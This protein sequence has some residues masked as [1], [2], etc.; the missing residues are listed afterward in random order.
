MMKKLRPAF[1]LLLLAFAVINVKAA[2]VVIRNDVDFALHSSRVTV[3]I[4][5][6]TNFSD[7]R[8]GRLRWRLWASEDRWDPEVKGHLL[9]LATLRPLG[10]HTNRE[11]VRRTRHLRRP[12]DSDDYYV[13]LTL[14]ERVR[15][16]DGNSHWEIRDTVEFDDRVYISESSFHFFPFY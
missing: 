10:A 14:E 16:E 5:D 15:D 3:W 2:D 4:E 6:L 13:T 9:S 1:S 8:S 11:D 7:E 12:H